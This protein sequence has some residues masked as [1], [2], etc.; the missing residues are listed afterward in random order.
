MLPPDFYWSSG[1]HSR[2]SEEAVFNYWDERNG[3]GWR[4]FSRILSQGTVA[5]AP[6]WN[7]GRQ[8]ARPSRVAPAAANRR[9]NIDR[10][11][12][13]WYG[14][15]EFRT[16]GRWYCIIFK[17]AA[18]NRIVLL[19]LPRPNQRLERT[20][21]ERASFLSC[22]SEPPKRNGGSVDIFESECKMRP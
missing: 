22:L 11:R 7:N 14:I 3:R 6:W 10:N 21:H 5:M 2:V 1:H 12:I 20:R 16:D 17:E 13:T 15:F 8:P 4:A 9:S 18:R 19:I